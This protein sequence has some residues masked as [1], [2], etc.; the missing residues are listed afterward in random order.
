MAD[1]AKRDPGRQGTRCHPEAAIS[2]RKF[3]QGA[4]V[5][6]AAAGAAAL[7]ARAR[8]GTARTPTSAVA[9]AAA[10]GLDAEA[11]QVLTP[12]QGR[13][14]AAVLNR[15]IPANDVMPGAGDAGIARFIDGVLAEAPHLRPHVIA[16][17]HEADARERFAGLTEAEQDARLREMARRHREW[18]DTLLRSAYTGYYSEPRVLAALGRGSHAEVA[19]PRHFDT[20][21]LDA[22]R[23]RGPIYR[24]ASV[25]GRSV[26]R[27]TEAGRRLGPGPAARAT[28]DGGPS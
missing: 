24:D 7:P 26:A 17:L 9:E 25:A 23:K 16:L 27:G 10:G 22:V 12:E 20:S 4:V 11:Y 6:S 15:I 28:S 8:A 19:S 14:L 13:V 1:R 21:R 18:F 3:I 2:R 5:V